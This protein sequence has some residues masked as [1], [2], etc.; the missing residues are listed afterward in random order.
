MLPLN[1]HKLT[2]LIQ[3][4][5][6]DG[7]LPH[8]P[9][10]PFF[11]YKSTFHQPGD[12]RVHIDFSLHVID[13]PSTNLGIWRCRINIW[14]KEKND[15]VDKPKALS[16]YIEGFQMAFD[17]AE[18]FV[19]TKYGLKKILAPQTKEQLKERYELLEAI[20]I[21]REKSGVVK[22]VGRKD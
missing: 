21:E 18:R 14:L 13:K 12:D 16:Y 1:H 19:E 22:R 6:C 4:I 11:S 20:R 5:I 7:T 17:E 2:T 8:I 15:L 9:A 10:N 3:H